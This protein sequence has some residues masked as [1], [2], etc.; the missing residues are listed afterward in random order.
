MGEVRLTCAAP[1]L[2]VG[3]GDE[4]GDG[5]GELGH[6]ARAAGDRGDLFNHSLGGDVSLDVAV[7]GAFEVAKCETGFS[8]HNSSA[9]KRKGGTFQIGRLMGC[10]TRR[11]QATCN[12]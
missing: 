3:L 1:R 12:N 9:T 4:R 7:Q 2:V 8:L 11:F 5:G 10:E 6:G